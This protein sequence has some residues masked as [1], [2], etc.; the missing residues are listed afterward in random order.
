MKKL[1][2]LVLALAFILSLS[3]C[4]NK[5]NIGGQNNNT[6]NSSYGSSS[7]ES[8]TPAP[9][10]VAPQ[11]N[12]TSDVNTV[13]ITQDKAL[14]IALKHFSLKKENV[15]EIEVE[16]DRERKGIVWDVDFESGNIDY[17]V[18]INSETGEIVKAEKEIDN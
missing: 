18:E 7:G 10:Y 12:G 14:E 11:S 2:A 16:L 4:T 3:A 13:K 5:Q 17:S 9:E 1:L 15:R 8:S 6:T